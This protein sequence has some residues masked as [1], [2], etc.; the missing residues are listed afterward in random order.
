M[1][2]EDGEMVN[3]KVY[4]VSFVGDVSSS[5]TVMILPGDLAVAGCF[6]FFGGFI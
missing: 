4:K 3:E 6:Y 1:C 5:R 2:E